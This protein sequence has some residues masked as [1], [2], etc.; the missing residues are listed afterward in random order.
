MSGQ[1]RELIAFHGLVTNPNELAA[2]GAGAMREFTNMSALRSDLAQ[3][4][5]GVVRCAVDSQPVNA[6]F[7]YDGGMIHHSG[8]SSNGRLKKFTPSTNVVLSYGVQI[9]PISGRLRGCVSGKN[10]YYAGTIPG[11]LSGISG[12]PTNAGG[13]FAPGFDKLATTFPAGTLLEDGRSVAYRCLFGFTD[14]KDNVILGNASSRLVITNNS[15]VDTSPTIRAII[16]S[17]ATTNHFIQFYR[18]KSINAPTQ[19]DDEMSLVYEQQLKATDISAGYLDLADIVPEALLGNTYLYSNLN[20]GFGTEEDRKPNMSPPSCMEVCNFA[21]RTWFAN[22]IIPGQYEFSILAVAQSTGIQPGDIL[23]FSKIGN[24]FDLTAKRNFTVSTI[25]RTSNVVTVTTSGAHGFSTADSVTLGGKVTAAA[26]ATSNGAGPFTITVT[27]ATTFTYAETG[28]DYAPA[29]SPPPWS[30]WKTLTDGQYLLETTGTASYN[31]RETALNFVSAF[32][33]YTGNTWAWATW[34]SAPE[35]LDQAKILIR[36]RTNATGAFTVTVGVTSKRGAFQPLMSPNTVTYTAQRIAPNIVT[37]IVTGGTH[38]LVVGETITVLGGTPVSG[39]TFAAGNVQIIAPVTTTD[40]TYAETGTVGAA[41]LQTAVLYPTDVTEST[42]EVKPNRVYWSKQQ[43]HE[44]CTEAGWVDVGSSDTGIKAMKPQRGQ[45]WVWKDEGI[46]RIRGDNP[47]NFSVEAMDTSLRVLATESIVLFNNRCWGLTDRGVVAVSESGIEVMSTAI[48]NELRLMAINVANT[49][50]TSVADGFGLMGVDADCFAVAYES[51][52]SYILHFPDAAT[53]DVNGKYGTCRYAFVY[54]APA[55][56][57]DRPG[58]WATWD[59]NRETQ[60]VS[61]FTVTFRG[62]RCGIVGFVDDK[63]YLAEGFNGKN[64]LATIFQELKSSTATLNYDED[65]SCALGSV[66]LTRTSGTTVVAT[67]A[68][69]TE[70]IPAIGA[71][72]R[73]VPTT[74]GVAGGTGFTELGPFTV[75]ARTSNTFTFTSNGSNVTLGGVSIVTVNPVAASMTWLL[76][77]SGA[78]GMEKRWDEIELLFVPAKLTQTGAYSNTQVAVG[79][80]LSNEASSTSITLASQ[81]MQTARAW[82]PVDMARGTR[83][84]VRVT[85]SGAGEFFSLAGLAVKSEVLDGAVTR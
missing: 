17:N 30:V 51:E 39:S 42:V 9:N 29:D 69:G 57:V 38:T 15:G 47:N 79:L 49:A 44:A 72:V 1:L 26:A 61:P 40:F 13:L 67:V 34:L 16:P 70:T 23:T 19:P 73:L 24:S 21:D 36:G 56:G 78:P 45:I 58:T 14:A 83:L 52:R 27:G 31:N 3:K 25:S 41:L 71:R 7:N 33:K 60:V 50:A 84:L 2:A 80:T 8:S 12:T 65:A 6:M 46:F 20:S 74:S 62:K 5:R 66:S 22:T 59:W 81:G 76:Q 64:D 77:T 43:K 53:F 85:H 28:A 55:P 18:G 48:D 68:A 10:F 32:N 35:S 82:V 54:T 11:R 75:T 37:C 63:M 4:R